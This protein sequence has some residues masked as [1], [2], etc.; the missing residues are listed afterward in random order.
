MH[1]K[2]LNILTYFNNVARAKEKKKELEKKKPD[3][4]DSEEAKSS[5]KSEKKKYQRKVKKRF[6][7]PQLNTKHFLVKT[8][9]GTLWGC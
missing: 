2:C 1:E 5:P 3:E 6:K 4:E 8:N 7:S 9:N